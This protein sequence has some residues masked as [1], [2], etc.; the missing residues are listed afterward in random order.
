LASTLQLNTDLVSSTN[1]QKSMIVH[2]QH[3]LHGSAIIRAVFLLL[4]WLAVWQ[5]GT[6]VEY[7]E[8]ASVWFPPAGFTFACMLVLGKRAFLPIM[9]AAIIITYWQANLYQ[10]PLNAL[11]LAWAGILFGLAH[12]FP[13]WLGAILI[14]HLSN[15]KNH[16]APQLIISFLLVGVISAF[17]TTVL[18]ISSL[19]I[20]DQM[21][22][23]EVR[24]T[25]LP[26]WVGDFTGIVVLTPLFSG[27][28]IFLYPEPK[29]SLN[30]FTDE[31]LGAYKR[32]LYK[33]SI[34]VLMITNTMILAYLFDSKESA[35]AIFFLAITHMWI[36]C[37][38]SPKFNVISLAISSVLIIL[39]V[40]YLGLMDYVMVYQFAIIVIAANALFGI[41]VPQLQAHNQALQHLV[42]TDSLTQVSSRHYMEQRADL[43]I[44]QSL[45]NGS[46]LSIVV[47]DLDDFKM[48]NDQFGHTAGDA[49]LKYICNTTKAFL[50]RNDVIARFGG[51]EFVLLLPGLKQSETQAVVE[52][53]KQ[54]IQTHEQNEQATTASF[55]IATLLPS[56]DFASLFRRADQALYQSKQQGGNTI[57]V[58]T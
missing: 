29:L 19:F 33:V 32:L 39:L 20:T 30:E 37:T 25:L 42:Y 36:A 44:A 45:E 18:V 8:H 56:D 50:R 57:T 49:A 24:Q 55:G 26:F 14:R 16:G 13:Y 54:A 48:V 38:E 58:A 41:A 6:L 7:T 40:H 47:F 17:I 31:K 34:N 52:R 12:I 1:G 3:A 28:L 4:A 2:L 10:S 35:F 53:V 9:A 46:P 11:E 15:K 21:P 51:D 5:S 22:I 43:E 23:E 27:M